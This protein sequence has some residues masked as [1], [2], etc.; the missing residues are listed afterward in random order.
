MVQGHLPEAKGRLREKQ[1]LAWPGTGGFTFLRR[2]GRSD[3]SFQ[4]RRY[5]PRRK[6]AIAFFYTLCPSG[7]MADAILWKDRVREW[8]GKLTQKEAADILDVPATTLRAWEY[9]KRQPK[10]ASAQEFERRMET[11]P[12]EP[13]PKTQ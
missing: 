12:N 3:V 4:F 10:K 13:P 7:V 6:K 1:V 8:R 9:G 5:A 11:H 2:K